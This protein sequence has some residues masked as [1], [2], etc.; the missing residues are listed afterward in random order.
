MVKPIK[1]FI[2][3]ENIQLIEYPLYSELHLRVIGHVKSSL[4]FL[5]S[6]Y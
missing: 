6:N 5:C 4:P 1:L 2:L 3:L